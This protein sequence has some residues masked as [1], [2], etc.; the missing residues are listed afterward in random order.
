M[1]Y[2]FDYNFQALLN[3]VLLLDQSPSSEEFVSFIQG[4]T[5]ACRACEFDLDI[6]PATY[7]AMTTC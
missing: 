5:G 1:P 6:S 7:E 4:H 2:T 3:D